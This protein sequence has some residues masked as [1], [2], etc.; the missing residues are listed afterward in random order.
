MPTDSG[1]YCNGQLVGTKYGMSAVA[2]SSWWGRCPS[3][4]EVK[5]LTESDAKA[6]YAWYFDNFGLFGIENQLFFELVAN[7][8]MGS[9]A[10]AARVAQ[11]V[12]NQFGYSVEIDGAF[13]P[14]TINAL[15]SA[16]RSKG[17]VIYNAMREAWVTYLVNLNR[18]EFIE[19]WLYRMNRFFPAL[20]AN[21]GLNLGLALLVLAIGYKFL[22][23]S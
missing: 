21:S 11:K 5:N 1:N 2:I 19:G 12:L 4:S 13:G 6:F 18:P 10:N 23:S 8:A 16:W 9:P 17:A 15:N 20:A 3:E 7:N 14:E 22:K